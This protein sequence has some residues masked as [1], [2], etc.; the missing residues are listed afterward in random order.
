MIFPIDFCQYIVC[1]FWIKLYYNNT[2]S[3]DLILNLI[4]KSV[5]SNNCISRACDQHISKN[6]TN[7]TFM[8][9]CTFCLNSILFYI[10]HILKP[11]TCILFFFLEFPSYIVLRRRPLEM[12]FSKTKTKKQ[13]LIC[14]YRSLLIVSYLMVKHLFFFLFFWVVP[15]KKKKKVFH[16]E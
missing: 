4:W 9:F 11:F 16:W 8:K 3:S 2:F 10:D 5:L 6:R 12:I 13:N 7:S 1:R 14:L 15:F